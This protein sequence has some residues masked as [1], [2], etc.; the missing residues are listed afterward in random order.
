MASRQISA[1]EWWRVLVAHAALTDAYGSN[2]AALPNPAQIDY[3]SLAAVFDDLPPGR[4]AV[5]QPTL[6]LETPP[7]TQ[8]PVSSLRE[9]PTLT[10]GSSDMI[11]RIRIALAALLTLTGITSGIIALSSA[12]PA[13]AKPNIQICNKSGGLFGM[14][15]ANVNGGVYQPGTKVIGWTKDDNNNAF[16]FNGTNLCGSGYV[17]QNCPFTVGSGL[18]AAYA[19]DQIVEEIN[20]PSGLCIGTATSQS[21][22]SILT[23]CGSGW[24]TFDILEF[25]NLPSGG[26]TTPYDIVINRNWSDND[27]ANHNINGCSGKTCTAVQGMAGKGV[28]FFMAQSDINVENGNPSAAIPE[29]QWAEF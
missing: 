13:S 24:S 26:S 4:V 15:C 11:R 19:G 14:Y 8:T 2:N 3:G 22:A 29:D 25:A 18:N 5:V 12:T 27:W 7:A 17:T 1:V 20:S 10:K 28:Q 16:D 21:Y 6:P 23:Q 9:R